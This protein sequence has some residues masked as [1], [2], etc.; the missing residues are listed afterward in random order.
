VAR[1]RWFAHANVNAVDLADSEHFYTSHLELEPQGRTA[2]ATTQDGAGFGLAGVPVRWRGVFLADHR[3]PRG[4]VVDLL[5]WLEPPTEGVAYQRPDHLGLIAL[6]F[7]VPDPDAMAVRLVAAGAPAAREDGLI[8]TADPSGTRIE[9]FAADGPITYAGLRVNCSDL[10][11][12]VA[13]YR[14][15]LHLDADEP[16]ATD[17]WTAQRLYLPGQRDQFSVH[18]TQWRS[19]SVGTPY[20]AGHHAGIYR[21]ALFADDADASYEDVRRVVPEVAPPVVV[22][23]GEGLADVWAIFFPDPDG[24]V[25]ELVGRV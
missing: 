2:P 10:E 11:R 23:L 19:G 3:G 25:L 22:A 12:S 13:F 1:P 21:T 14:A 6:R 24:A 9:L 4:P 17:R 7:G 8:V 16:E 18:L 5:Q 15:A 20:A